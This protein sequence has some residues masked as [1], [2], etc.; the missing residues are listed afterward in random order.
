MASQKAT[1]KRKTPRKTK[2]TGNDAGNGAP[3]KALAFPPKIRGKAKSPERVKVEAYL[4]SHQDATAKQIEAD[5]GI[6]A[7]KAQTI[8]NNITQAK[9]KKGKRGRKKV[10]KAAVAKRAK[11]RAVTKGDS[12]HHDALDAAAALVKAVGGSLHDAI[13]YLGKLMP[14]SRQ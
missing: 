6:D 10:A 2:A 14:F 11:A 13:E 7:K 9:G 12:S 5:T 4:A 8:K 1:P 3:D